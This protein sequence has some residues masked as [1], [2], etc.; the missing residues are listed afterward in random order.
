MSEVHDHVLV[1]GTRLLLSGFGELL[2]VRI[3]WGGMQK[4]RR[5]RELR[6]HFALNLS[7]HHLLNGLMWIEMDLRGEEGGTG[8]EVE[9]EWKVS[10][11]RRPT[12]TAWGRQ[13]KADTW[14]GQ[15]RLYTVQMRGQ[16]LTDVGRMQ[17]RSP[18]VTGREHR[19]CSHAG[20]PR[21]FENSFTFSPAPTLSLPICSC[22]LPQSTL[23]Q[24]FRCRRDHSGVLWLKMARYGNG[25]GGCRVENRSL[26]QQRSGGIDVLAVCGCG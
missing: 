1:E 17:D 26:S 14:E 10:H 3:I 13:A 4:L 12:L 5:I 8:A 2:H 15:L 25:A 18:W 24:P 9:R 23:P 20:L 6:G 19:Q 7:S 21:A 11:G 22:I 16:K